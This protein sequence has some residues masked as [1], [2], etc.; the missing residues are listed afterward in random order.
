MKKV[1][2]VIL[3]VLMLASCLAGVA[4]ADIEAPEERTETINVTFYYYIDNK[5]WVYENGDAK[6]E[7]KSLTIQL[8]PG[9]EY[10]VDDWKYVV[11]ADMPKEFTHDYPVEYSMTETKTYIFSHFTRSTDESGEKL[12]IANLNTLTEDTV[13]YAQYKIE[14]TIEYTTFWEFVQSVFA[15]INIIFE[16]F[17]EIFGF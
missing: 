1:L 10:S 4:Y 15:R 6:P 3:S 11:L 2:A 9:E 5:K 16:Y 14:D 8:A 13:L 7:Q 12:Y 17:A